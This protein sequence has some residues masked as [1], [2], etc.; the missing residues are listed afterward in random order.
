MGLTSVFGCGK[1]SGMEPLTEPIAGTSVV[2]RDSSWLVDTS[3]GEVVVRARSIAGPA[4]GR[5]PLVFWDEFRV[6]AVFA[7]GEW[8]WVRRE[9]ALPRLFGEEG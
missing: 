6:V 7:E 4:S 5:G 2:D 9:D 3:S 1:V 8:R